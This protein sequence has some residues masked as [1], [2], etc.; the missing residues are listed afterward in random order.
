MPARDLERRGVLTQVNKISDFGYLYLY[1][2]ASPLDSGQLIKE[3][4]SPEES[5]ALEYFQ[6]GRP[7]LLMVGD[8]MSEIK[9]HN[10]QYDTGQ[11][12]IVQTRKPIT[13][14]AEPATEAETIVLPADS[15]V[16]DYREMMAEGIGDGYVPQILAGYID[17][18]EKEWAPVI[19]GQAL[20]VIGWAEPVALDKVLPAPFGWDD[21]GGEMDWE[22]TVKGMN[23]AYPLF[24]NG[25]GYTP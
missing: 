23:E 22:S 3:P 16:V 5:A 20:Q 15:S 7:P 6:L 21:L 19:D 4:L 25:T 12:R 18:E 11:C 9:E 10:T 2:S 13:L 8:G 24:I 17:M 1:I 14:H